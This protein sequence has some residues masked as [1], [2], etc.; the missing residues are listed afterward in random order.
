MPG[1]IRTLGLSVPVS[2]ILDPELWKARYAVGIQGFGVPLEGAGTLT[3]ALST[4][5][6]TDA[7]A[8]LVGRIPNSTILWHLRVALSELQMKLNIKLGIEVIKSDPVDPGLVLGVH[9]DRFH[10]RIPYTRGETLQWFLIS[11]PHK[12]VVSV[13]RIRGF[14]FGQKVWEISDSQDN[15]SLI[16]IEHPK[17]GSIHILPTQLE[18][19]II[20]NNATGAGNYG[21]W[22]TINLHT[23]PVP[24]FWAV[25]WTAGPVDVNGEVGKIEAVLAHWVYTVAGLT[26]LS[27]A[28]LAASKGL[29]SSSVSFDGI[30]RSVSLQASAIYG[31]NS[32]LEE[33][34][35]QT[36]KRIDWKQLRMQKQGLRI[37][38]YSY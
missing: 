17:Q 13:E 27:I 35:R 18:S 22:E 4:K 16:R 30:S 19:L 36:Q 11:L 12:P 26:L 37:R 34:F 1:F 21:I 32:A 9:Y 10:P 2:D 24:D 38:K 23:S 31:L 7:L 15:R 6:G 20:T 33:V 14:Y 29:S 8:D 3:G 25:D 28:G 5:V